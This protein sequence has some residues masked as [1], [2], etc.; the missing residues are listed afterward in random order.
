M[1]E[2]DFSAISLLDIY[3]NTMKK[4]SVVKAAAMAQQQMS[5]DNKKDT[6]GKI[7][8]MSEAGK[9]KSEVYS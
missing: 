1:V 7:L 5:G 2:D 3:K 9:H 8:L 6:G 4:L